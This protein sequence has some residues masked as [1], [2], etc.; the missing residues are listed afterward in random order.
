MEP[1]LPM[2]HQS[3]MQAADGWPNAHA[4][5]YARAKAYDEAAAPS[6]AVRPLA[7]SSDSAPRPAPVPGPLR[8]KRSPKA[9][10]SASYLARYG[11]RMGGPGSLMSPNSDAGALIGAA[12]RDESSHAARWRMRVEPR[13]VRPPTP[14]LRRAP[15]APHPRLLGRWS[16]W[17]R[18]CSL[19]PLPLRRA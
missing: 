11:S 7:L 1:G 4:S 3:F 17:M 8:S 13:A 6:A 10:K 19:W 16:S 18:C 2:R 12:Q 15:H 9:P 14:D 5:P